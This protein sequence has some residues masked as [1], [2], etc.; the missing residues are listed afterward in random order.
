[1]LDIHINWDGPYTLA[2]TKN[3]NSDSDFGIYQYYGSHPVY[4][5]NVLV[6][7]GK[8]E[9][10][11]FAQRLL[12]H[13]WHLWLPDITEVYVGK[14]CSE[15]PLNNAEWE[16]LIDLAERILI[17]SHSPAFNSS[18]L[19]LIGN[20][21]GDTRV[22]NWGKRKS[23]LPEVSISRWEGG[24]TTGHIIPKGLKPWTSQNR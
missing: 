21:G 22:I 4:G 10:Q 14:I 12:Q 18:N 9:K 15:A 2:E 13:N 23:L 6:Y 20:N 17:F 8:A 11:T 1:M 5:S 7:I 16:R 19:N 24:L 3:L